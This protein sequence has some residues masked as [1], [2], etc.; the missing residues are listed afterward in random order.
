[1][2]SS[3]GAGPGQF[4]VGRSLCLTLDGGTTSLGDLPGGVVQGIATGVSADGSVI[5]GVGSSAE[6]DP[7]EAFRWTAGTGFVGLGDLPRRALLTARLR[8]RPDDGR[9]IFISV[10]T[11]RT[12][13]RL[14]TLPPASVPMDSGGRMVGLGDLPGGQHFSGFGCVIRRQRH[15]GFW[16]PL[17]GTLRHSGGPWPGAWSSSALSPPNGG[18]ASAVSGRWHS[19]AGISSDSNDDGIAWIWTSGDRNTEAAGSFLAQGATGLEN[20][21]P[22]YVRDISDGRWPVGDAINPDGVERSA[23]IWTRAS[24]RCRLQWLLAPVFGCGLAGRGVARRGAK[25]CASESL[26]ESSS[27]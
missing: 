20:W 25:S 24:A 14:R 7:F 3:A 16:P 23:H 18:S 4:D 26:R 17:H 13:D 6:A 8:A 11:V 12:R 15:R 27:A 22:R 21:R 2:W 5:V 9:V 10:A 19:V 1:M